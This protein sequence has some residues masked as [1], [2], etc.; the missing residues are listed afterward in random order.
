MSQI[1]IEVQRR[2]GKMQ[3]WCS[4]TIGNALVVILANGT[5]RDSLYLEHVCGSTDGRM[6]ETRIVQALYPALGARA[7][8]FLRAS[9]WAEFDPTTCVITLHYAGPDLRVCVEHTDITGASRRMYADFDAAVTE[10]ARATH[11]PVKDV[12]FA[13][14]GGRYTLGTDSWHIVKPSTLLHTQ[15]TPDAQ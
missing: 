8:G 13:L 5:P 9:V 2:A 15:E 3:T 14:A 7:P 1:S 11:Q 10:T 6:Q 12:R 4:H